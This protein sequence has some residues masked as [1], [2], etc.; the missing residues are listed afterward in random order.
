MVVISTSY[1][2]EGGI[3]IIDNRKKIIDDLSDTERFLIEEKCRR[4]WNEKILQ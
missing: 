3:L 4:V 1:W 2:E